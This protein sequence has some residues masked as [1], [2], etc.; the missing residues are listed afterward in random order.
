MK[1]ARRSLLGA[2][3]VVLGFP[4]R[5][6]EFPSRPI[7]WVVPFPPAGN[8]DVTSRIVGEAIAAS[9]HAPPCEPRQ[10][11]LLQGAVGQTW[12]ALTTNP[13]REEFIARVTALDTTHQQA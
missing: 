3:A 4:A 8:Y 13:Q 12:D 6:Q 5:A 11:A 1:F 10:L 2:G 7:R 9:A